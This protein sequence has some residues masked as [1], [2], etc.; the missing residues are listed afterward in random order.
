ME[1]DRVYILNYAIRPIPHCNRGGSHIYLSNLHCAYRKS[2]R[3]H[4]KFC[5][6]SLSLSFSLLLFHEFALMITGEMVSFLIYYTLNACIISY[7]Y[8]VV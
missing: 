5:D 2:L 1:D 8:V 6:Q 7:I 4:C 3:F